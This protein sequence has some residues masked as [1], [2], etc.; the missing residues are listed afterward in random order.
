MVTN[1]EVLFIYKGDKLVSAGSL[2]SLDVDNNG[3]VNLRFTATREYKF[4]YWRAF[5]IELAKYLDKKG[6]K[7]ASFTIFDR[8][9]EHIKFYDQFGKVASVGTLYEIPK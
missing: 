9:P 5:V 7:N 2:N 1:H 6:L 8:Q 4:E 3:R